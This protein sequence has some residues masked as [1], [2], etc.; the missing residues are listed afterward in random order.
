MAAKMPREVTAGVGAGAGTMG[1]GPGMHAALVHVRLR[2]VCATQGRVRLCYPCGTTCLKRPHL[3]ALCA[4]AADRLHTP[5][6]VRPLWPCAF[7]T[8][9]QLPALTTSCRTTTAP[10]SRRPPVPPRPPPLPP[11]P[12]PAPPLPCSTPSRPASPG[13]RASSWATSS[14]S[15]SPRGSRCVRRRGCWC[16][17]VQGLVRAARR[18]KWRARV[19]ELLGWW[20]GHPYT[21]AR[22]VPTTCPPTPHPLRNRPSIPACGSW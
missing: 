20:A 8:H 22:A 11:P 15:G 6:P 4:S 13:S 12:P 17:V 3:V 7:P 5:P 21:R 19:L 9:S 16:G 14:S 1:P 2:R 10:V 18:R